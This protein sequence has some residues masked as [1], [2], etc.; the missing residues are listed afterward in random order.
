MKVRAVVAALALVLASALAPPLARAQDAGSVLL[1]YQRNFVRSS[2]GAKLELL[3]EAG[4]R[5]AEEMAPLYDTALR[6]AVESEPLLGA[7]DAQLRE[8]VLIAAA[9]AGEAA[10]APSAARLWALFRLYEGDVELRALAVAS[11]GAAGAGNEEVVAAVGEFLASQNVVF[12]SGMQPE[13]PALEAAVDALGRIGDGASFP[14]LFSTYVA[15][16]NPDLTAKASKALGR[17][18]GDYAGYLARVLAMSSPLEKAA[19]LKAALENPAFGPEER[20]G[21]AEAALAAGLAWTGG[22]PVENQAIRELNLRAIRTIRELGWQRASPLVLRYFRALLADYAKGAAPRGDLLE[23]IVCLGA[24]GSS[25]AAQALALQLQLIN[26]QTELGGSYDD[27][28]IL[29]TIRALGEL[30]DKVA[31]DY[32]LYVG[33]LKY[34]DEVKRAA[35]EALLRLRW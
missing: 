31:F 8:L 14:V 1:T 28:V 17:I 10:Y 7:A 3:K 32:L 22:A 18:K 12:R 6:F 33:Y 16:Y 23:T 13:Y 11:L 24:M 19:A 2:L 21:L 26:A 25:E 35:K 4:A 9:K 29:A 27:E 34:P 30:G 20:G 5:N 15:G